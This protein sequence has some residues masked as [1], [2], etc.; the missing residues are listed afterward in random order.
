MKLLAD[1]WALV[2]GSS[3]GIGRQI[4]LGLAERK[5]NLIL[6]GR[7][8]GNTDETAKRL[9]GKGVLVRSV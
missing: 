5:C 1:K 3:R 2:T 4:A 6:H 8:P 7:V 9:A